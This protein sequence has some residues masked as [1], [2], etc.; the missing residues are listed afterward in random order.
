MKH[1]IIYT[2]DYALIV[3]DEEMVEGDYALLKNK[4]Y[5]EIQKA[6]PSCLKNSFRNAE[7]WN[8]ENRVHNTGHRKIIAH[9]P[10]TDAP[11]LEGVPLL[12]EFSED[13]ELNNL[14]GDYIKKEVEPIII[15][16][17]SQDYRIGVYGGS[18]IGFRKGYTKAKETY[19]YTEEN[20]RKAFT[21]Y[22]FS[23]TSNQP[24]N[25]EELEE[26]FNKFIQSLQQSKRPKYFACETIYRVKSGTI[27][28]HKDGLAGFEYYE[29]KSVTN[30]Q[31]Q[32]EL[33]GT[34]IF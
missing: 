27:Q 16:N 1:E 34:Y 28:E 13:G 7:C 20:L 3:S 22:A 23:S 11:I 6:L 19:R 10:L 25:E 4:D 5:F 24:Y 31:N 18:D 15:K 8:A 14:V 26:S 30:S 32:K 21:K 9:R 33:V 17:S 29:P 12:P 2:D